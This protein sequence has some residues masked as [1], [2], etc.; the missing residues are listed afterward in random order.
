MDKRTVSIWLL[1]QSQSDEF[2]L[3]FCNLL[4][5]GQV[6]VAANLGY[7]QGSNSLEALQT[8]DAEVEVVTLHPFDCTAHSVYDC[9]N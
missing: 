5:L 8:A 4:G 1:A 3:A 6:V 7:S 2:A 9:C